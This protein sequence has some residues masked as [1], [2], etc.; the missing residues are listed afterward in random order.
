[1]FFHHI[2]AS[3]LIQCRIKWEPNT[4]V[5]WDNVST[6]HHACWDYF[7][8]SRYGERVSAVGVGLHAAA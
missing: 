3:P 6:Q 1:M 8:Q 7:P 4:L 2:E 5:V